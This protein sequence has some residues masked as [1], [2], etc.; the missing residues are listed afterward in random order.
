M[1]TKAPQ[2]PDRPWHVPVRLEDVPDEGRHIDLSPDGETRAA[3]AAFA[4]L[5]TL[6]ELT[7]AFDLQRQG[8]DGLRVTG[9]VRARVGQVCVVSLDPLENEV[10]EPVDVV[11]KPAQAAPAAAPA[12][13]ESEES[14][15]P[16]EEP[17]EPLV[18]GAIDL[19]A[20]ATEFL[21]LGV[22]PYPRKP[23]AVFVA[24]EAGDGEDGPFAA[25]ARL[26][27]RGPGRT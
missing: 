21:V 15:L 22:D 19:G 23:D 8:S 4:G 25:L 16:A 12:S 9:E 24:P 6:P 2:P 14:A 11:F 5:R 17:P 3:L 18:D 10:V 13:S 20:L 1:T 27:E 7:A 26:K